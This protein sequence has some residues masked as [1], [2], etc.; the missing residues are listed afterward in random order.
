MVYSTE[1]IIQ[2]LVGCLNCYRMREGG[3]E[4]GAKG[5]FLSLSLYIYAMNNDAAK[6]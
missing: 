6:I 4:K 2:A 1:I 5:N 3:S